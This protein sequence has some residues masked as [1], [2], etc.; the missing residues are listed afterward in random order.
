MT[1]RLL[2]AGIALLTLLMEIRY[3][4]SRLTAAQVLSASLA[5][6]QAL[7]DGWNVIQAKEIA[8]HEQLSDALSWSNYA[9]LE[10]PYAVN[11]EIF[12]L[13][14]SPGTLQARLY[15]PNQ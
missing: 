12:T 1:A 7:R 3:T 15:Q 13:R 9:S 5:K 4:I 11:N 6:F 14:C 8:L 10:A 2:R